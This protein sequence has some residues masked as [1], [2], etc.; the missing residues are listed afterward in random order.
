MHAAILASTK[1][2]PMDQSGRDR[3]HIQNEESAMNEPITTTV[4]L[5]TDELEV[6]VA[7]IQ[8]LRDMD[9]FARKTLH[10]KLWSALKEAAAREDA[11]LPAR[12]SSSKRRPVPVR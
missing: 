3:E 7:A 12:S 4:L 9:P 10:D 8:D 1:V 11:D 6:L 5:T 2:G